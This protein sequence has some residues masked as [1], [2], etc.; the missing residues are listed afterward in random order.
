[1]I[2]LVTR[3][4]LVTQS[5]RLCLDFREA[6]PRDI[7]SQAKRLEVIETDARIAIMTND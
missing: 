6:E 4:C 7:D 2:L 5:P 3:I 1:M